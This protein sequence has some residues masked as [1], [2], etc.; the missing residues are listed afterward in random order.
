MPNGTAELGR[1]IIRSTLGGALGSWCRIGPAWPIGTANDAS[2]LAIYNITTDSSRTPAR[3]YAATDKGLFYSDNAYQSG[4]PPTTVPCSQVTW[5]PLSQPSNPNGLPAL[6]GQPDQVNNVLVSKR[7]NKILYASIAS[8]VALPNNNGFYRGVFSANEATITWTPI[9]SGIPDNTQR[10]FIRNDAAIATNAPSGQDIL[11]ASLFSD[12]HDPMRLCKDA[13]DVQQRVYRGISTD[14]STTWTR[15]ETA[16]GGCPDCQPGGNF[17]FNCE[18]NIRS[19]ETHP[20]S[21]GTIA[22]GADNV[23][24]S[25]DGA[26]T[27]TWITN[28]PEGVHP[29]HT[30]LAFGPPPTPGGPNSLY[31]GNDG[32]V[33]RR[34]NFATAPWTNLNSTL[35]NILFYGGMTDA[36]NYGTSWGGTQDN[37][38]MKGGTG[39]TWYQVQGGDGSR[40]TVDYKDSNVAYFV[41]A[42]TLDGGLTKTSLRTCALAVPGPDPAWGTLVMDPSV[43][44][45]LSIYA[46]GKVYRT[47]NGG[48]SDCAGGGWGSITGSPSAIPGVRTLSIAPS[49]APPSPSNFLLAAIGDDAPTNGT[50]WRTTDANAWSVISQ[51]TQPNGRGLP[52]ATVTNLTV[53]PGPCTVASC[54]F[55]AS[56]SGFGINHAYRS[57]NGGVDWDTVSGSG[58]SALADCP[59]NHLVVHPGNPTVLWA[60]TDL[61]VFQ[62]CLACKSQDG[63]TCNAN[64]ATTICNSNGVFWFWGTYNNNLPPGSSSITCRC[65]ATQECSAPSR[66]VAAHGRLKP[67]LPR[68]RT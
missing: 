14:T 43:S 60:A 61:G 57:T 51:P 22:V 7:D 21:T 38:D 1:G 13:G 47:T 56:L 42:K 31:T 35:A 24:L 29:D 44:K 46:S 19:I 15:L 53:A 63:I 26:N 68:I 3:I 33:W 8:N 52:N 48:S 27:F 49:Q 58:S 64:G 18:H 66:S 10:R 32:G 4:S 11:Y 16:G 30:D 34:N 2:H 41:N 5:T 25:T 65:M 36:L 37:G 45:S 55:Y 40:N 67:S 12:A 39:L 20:T 9:N 17:H 28:G 62:G 59:V 23:Y 6:N 54:T 50:V